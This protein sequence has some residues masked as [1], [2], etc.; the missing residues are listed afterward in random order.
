MAP[1]LHASTTTPAKA[2]HYNTALSAA[3]LAGPWG[4]NTLVKAPNGSPL[5][6]SESIRKWSKHT[7]GRELIR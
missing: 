7:G 2:Q 1:L 3:L 4:D 6:W 5:D